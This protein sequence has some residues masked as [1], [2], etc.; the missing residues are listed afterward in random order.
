[1]LHWNEI[2]WLKNVIL[3][4]TE[5]YW[6]EKASWM[7]TDINMGLLTMTNR[8]K[9][10]HAEFL[11]RVVRI[12]DWQLLTIIAQFHSI[13]QIASPDMATCQPLNITLTQWLKIHSFER[14]D[15][16]HLTKVTTSRKHCNTHTQNMP[17][18]DQQ[19]W[20]KMLT[21]CINSRPQST[22]K[23]ANDKELYC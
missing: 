23:H 20:G 15:L 3:N 17:N 21:G 13:T 19:T 2:F 4:V 14:N 9:T 11:I 18:A 1:M 7:S 16:D 8:P 6:L 10:K 12:Y 5:L 22:L